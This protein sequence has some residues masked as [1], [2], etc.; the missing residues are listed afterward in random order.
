MVRLTRL[1]RLLGLLIKGDCGS[2]WGGFCWFSY[3]GCGIIALFVRFR[4]GAPLST[5]HDD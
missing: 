2:W 4:A 1:T 5:S 3:A